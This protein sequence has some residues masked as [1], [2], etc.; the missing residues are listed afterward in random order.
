METVCEP[1]IVVM[2]PLSVLRSK[3]IGLGFVITYYAE[4]VFS[5]MNTTNVWRGGYRSNGKP[6]R[7]CGPKVSVGV[8]I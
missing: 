8:A 4:T 1:P 3:R 6:N 7:L 2:V 5:Y